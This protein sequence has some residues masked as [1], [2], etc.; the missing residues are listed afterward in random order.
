MFAHPSHT[1][2]ETAPEKVLRLALDLPRTQTELE[3]EAIRIEQLLDNLSQPL[4][5]TGDDLQNHLADAMEFLLQGIFGLLDAETRAE[6]D[7]ACAA[8]LQCHQLVQELQEALEELEEETVLV[9]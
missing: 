6:F 1:P 9:A 2:K 8:V 7:E 4:T 5:E 3:Q